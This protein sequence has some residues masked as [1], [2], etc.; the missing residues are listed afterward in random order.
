MV[1][2]ILI[3]SYDYR[4]M[5]GG[6]ATCAFE[7][8]Q[9]L[10][11]LEQV[12]VKVLAPKMEGDHEFDQ[13]ANFKTIRVPL[14]KRAITS[15]FKLRS[16]INKEIKEFRPNAIIN[17]LWMPDGVSTYLANTHSI[18][19]FQ[20]VHA[21]EVVETYSSLRKIIRSFLSPL[22][23][24]VINNSHEVFAVSNNTKKLIM[25][26]CNTPEN[27]ISVI[28]NGVNPNHFFPQEKKQALIDKYNLKDQF[29][30][31]TISRIKMFKGMDHAIIAMSKLKDLG[32]PFKYLI[33]GVGPDT[34]QLKDLIKKYEMND[35]VEF[36]GKIPTEEVIDYYNLCDCFITLSR[37]DYKT[38]N[39][40][41]FGLVFL[42][43]AACKVPS[44]AANSGGIP[45]AVTTE[46]GWLVD[47]EN[48]D[49][50]SKTIQDILNNQ[51]AVKSKGE[52]AHHRATQEM[53]WDHM[54]KKIKARL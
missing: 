43:A 18:P 10:N 16:K 47:P 14:N 19:V 25:R 42:E 20:M 4:P 46:T 21:V 12:E 54:A 35:F 7:L 51:E 48:I 13:Q 2:K 1:T 15:I 38:P 28:N 8:A 41:G 11:N 53:T 52:R 31:F 32:I 39:I 29:C 36:V 45:D 3:I 26:F 30:F 50:V 33:G 44:L 49:E 40:E 6:V 22:K 24:L 23:K 9:A 5:V 34:V 27:K 17:M 37:E